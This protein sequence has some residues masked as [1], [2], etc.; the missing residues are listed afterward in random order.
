MTLALPGAPFPVTY[1]E[2]YLPPGIKGWNGP[3]P[4]SVEGGHELAFTGARHGTTS[5]GVHS[6]GAVTGNINYGAIHDNAATYWISFR[7]RPDQPFSAA[8]ATDQYLWGKFVDATHFVW[9]VLRAAD[10]KLY[11]EGQDGGVNDFSIAAQNGA[12][13]ITAWNAGQFYDVIASISAANDVRLIVDNGTVVTVVTAIAFPNGGDFIVGDYDDPGAGT[14]F[15]GVIVD[16]FGSTIDNT[17]AE[18]YDLYAGIP[19]VDVVNAWLLDEGRGVTSYDRGT[20]GNDG[21]LDTTATWA[22][23]QVQQPVIS[24]DG[25]NDHAASSTGV[26]ISGDISMIWVGKMKSTYDGLVANHYITRVVVDADNRIDMLYNA[27]IDEIQW[28]VQGS[29][30]LG[31]TGF[32]TKPAIDDYMILIGT[33]TLGGNMSFFL[34]GSLVDTDNGVGA[35]SAIG[36]ILYLGRAHAAVAWDISKPLFFALIDGAFTQAQALTYSRYLKN[37]F[38]LPITI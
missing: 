5:D 8:A 36:S 23:G 34:N 12:G 32:T 33:I 28:V 13:D 27:G 35:V 21:T 22:F 26:V 6:D 25:I 18:E 10:G 3:L 16:V 20:G 29:A 38:N 31:A 9:L 2:L 7:F 14:G 24:L 30:V 11:F 19:P 15:E 17:V 37:L 1:R 4:P